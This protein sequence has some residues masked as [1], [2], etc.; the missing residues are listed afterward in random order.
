MA[1]TNHTGTSSTLGVGLV[2]KRWFYRVWE[3]MP[4]LLSWSLLASPIIL[5][6][7]WPIAVAYFIIAFDLFWLLKSVRMS[8][9]LV[10]G[11]RAIKRAQK[12]DWDQRLGQLGNIEEAFSEAKQKLEG[13]SRS[14]FLGLVKLSSNKKQFHQMRAEVGRL[15]QITQHQRTL[16]HPDDIT[17]VIITAVYNESLD[18][19]R[20]SLESVLASEYDSKNIIFVLAYEQSGGTNTA[21]TAKVLEKEFSHK[22]GGYM[23]ICHPEN[24]PGEL[25]GKGAN[26][27]YAGRILKTYFQEQ[28]IEPEN[29]IVTT[30][31]AD[32]RP[33]KKY[34]SYLTYEYCINPS[35]IH[36]SY[37]PMAMFF[38]NIWDAPAP[39][40]VIATGNSFWLMMES[41]RHNRLR[42]FAAHAQSLR[43]LIDTD[44]WS[45]TTIVEDGHQYW[46]TFFTYDGDHMVAPLY[47]PI[48]QDAV[49]ADNY[50]KTF[51]NQYKQLRRWA[52]GASDIPFVI[53]NNIKNKHIAFGKKWLQFFRLLEG[54]ISWATAPLI[55][56]FAAWA[57]LFLNQEFNRQV[58]AH[59]LPVIA[60]RILTI[61]LIGQFITILLSLLMLPPRPKH[62]HKA[63]VIFMVL[64]WV[65]VPITS[66]FFG[67]AAALNAQTRL[68]FGRYPKVFDVT[69]KAVKK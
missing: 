28:N 39:M 41:V 9:G 7:V 23:S 17:H 43:T 26:I 64:Q 21:Q 25:P 45:V 59:Q 2:D 37:Q 8:L 63:K 29:V 48:Y 38:N 3:V 18:V 50:R 42:N 54:H 5:S 53:T 11:Y 14:G 61:A 6:L 19:L 40:R 22:F 66:I 27:T 67:S 49:L 35:R 24:T 34:L 16:I 36:F 32:H 30:L 65:L 13:V 10:E 69:E 57:P 60:S 44:F 47:V 62:Y 68:M 4:G 20:P 31:D 55:L 52:Y 15:E 58:V 12:I 56:T 1:Q 51:V 33:D 46:R